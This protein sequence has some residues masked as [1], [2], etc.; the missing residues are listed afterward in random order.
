MTEGHERRVE[1]TLGMCWEDR[2]VDGRDD[3]RLKSRRHQSIAVELLE[4]PRNGPM[5][6]RFTGSMLESSTKFTIA[7]C[8]SRTHSIPSMHTTSDSV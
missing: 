7:F 6:I 8:P 5:A 2:R 1:R 4:R 3:D